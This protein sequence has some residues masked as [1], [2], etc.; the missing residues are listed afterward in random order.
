MATILITTSSFGDMDDT[1]L[2][3]LRQAGFTP[4]L[5]PHGRKLTEAEAVVLVAEHRPVGILAGVEPLT[6]AVMAAGSG[7]QAIARCGIGMENVDRDAAEEL[8]IVVTNT[9]DAPTQAVAEITLGAML[10]LVRGIAR[11]SAAIHAG[12][13]ERPMG[14]LLARQTVGLLGLGRIGARLATLLAPFGCRILGHDPLVAG[15]PGVVSVDLQTLAAQSDIVSLHVPYLPATHHIVDEA[16]LRSMKPG[17]F[18]VN[19]ARGGLVDEAALD[20]AL[21]EG[22]LGGA[23]LDCFEQEPYSGPLCRHPNVVLT[24]HIGSYAREGRVIQE[25]QAVENLL[26]SLGKGTGHT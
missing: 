10:C 19:Y 25:T 8:G 26:R 20:R 17:A 14:A 13:W 2:G 7:L 4:V 11:S 16:L 1:P 21:A 5:N 3:L 15:L 18:L 24:G 22:R 23:A 12:R 6:R 9:P